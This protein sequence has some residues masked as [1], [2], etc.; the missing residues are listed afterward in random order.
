MTTL[1]IILSITL[2]IISMAFVILSALVISSIKNQDN[3]RKWQLGVQDLDELDTR[4]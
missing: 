3:H 1:L 4:D 2:G